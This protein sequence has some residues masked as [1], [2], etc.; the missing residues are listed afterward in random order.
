M[1]KVQATLADVSTDFTPAEPGT[2]ALLIEEIEDKTEQGREA[3]NI[4]L[5]ID[6]PGTDEHGKKIWDYISLSKKD[7]SPNQ[8]G[9]AQ[10]K[11]YFEAVFGDETVADPSFDYDTDE[12]LKQRVMGEVVIESW[13]KGEKGSP[14]YKTGKSNKIKMITSVND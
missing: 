14:S 8:A 1:P 5:T 11:R 13:E 9:K 4:I 2:Y 12:L 10:L 7:K 3:Y 6:E